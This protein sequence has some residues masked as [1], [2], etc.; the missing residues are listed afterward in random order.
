M[1]AEL[2]AGVS[3]QVPIFPHGGGRLLYEIIGGSDD[4]QYRTRHGFGRV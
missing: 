4:H 2:A 1:G 3:V